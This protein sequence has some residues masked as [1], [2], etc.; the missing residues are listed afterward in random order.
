MPYAAGPRAVVGVLLPGASAAVA[1]SDEV[2]EDHQVLGVVLRGVVVVTG[3]GDQPHLG[4]R[5]V[6]VHAVVG[7]VVL[8]EGLGVVDDEGRREA[9]AKSLAGV[10]G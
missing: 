3:A 7:E 2:G 4:L 8:L 9:V 1:R 6:G 5:G 10:P